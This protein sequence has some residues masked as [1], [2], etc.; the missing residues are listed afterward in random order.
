MWGK[1]PQQFQRWL[2]IR[3]THYTII[4]GLTASM[5]QRL[6]A[7]LLARK[8]YTISLCSSGTKNDGAVQILAICAKYMF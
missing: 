8:S 3:C 1:A 6:Y 5:I 4:G 2:S 7:I